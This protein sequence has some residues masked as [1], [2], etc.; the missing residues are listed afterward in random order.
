MHRICHRGDRFWAGKGC[1]QRI[2]LY[3]HNWMGSS[4]KDELSLRFSDVILRC[5]RDGFSYCRSRYC[6]LTN[7]RVGLFAGP[8][9]VHL[10]RFHVVH[11][12]ACRAW[13]L[14]WFLC[15][16]VGEIIPRF[17]ESGMRCSMQLIHTY[18]LRIRRCCIG[19]CG[20][21]FRSLWRML[22]GRNFFA[23]RVVGFDQA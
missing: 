23:G 13:W 21:V 9:H 15:P 12:T 7:D 11:A 3:A 20:V 14:I 18:G 19:G 1:C 17:L 22:P 8:I 6:L 4:A 2:Y 5:E 10:W 16:V